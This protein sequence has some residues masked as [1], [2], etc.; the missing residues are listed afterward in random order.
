MNFII[1]PHDSVLNNF[2]RMLQEMRLA[3][4]MEAATVQIE[5]VQTHPLNSRNLDDFR[6]YTEA[7]IRLRQ[8]R[9]V[10]YLSVAYNRYRPLHY[11][12]LAQIQTDGDL[13]IHALSDLLSDYVLIDDLILDDDVLKA[14]QETGYLTL[15]AKPDAVFYVGST[16]IPFIVNTKELHLRGFI[17]Q[18][19]VPMSV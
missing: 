9:R 6:E 8:G 19:S 12:A 13:D 16:T 18:P 17:S 10:R 1:D 2:I 14:A 11:H 4:P 15:A 5:S 7:S 3:S